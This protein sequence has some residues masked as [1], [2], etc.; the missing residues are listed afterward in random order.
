MQEL[1]VWDDPIGVGSD[2]KAHD[3]LV[4]IY[5]NPKMPLHTRMRAAIAAIPYESPKLAVT[6][7]MT[8][9]DFASILEARMRRFKK[10]EAA[11]VINAQPTP[12]VEVKP[13]LPT[14]A[15]R[16]YRRI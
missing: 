1:L 3:I 14:V 11:K 13:H 10:L 4:A 5:R 12:V 15:D 8:G 9:K 7:V 16:R 2:A 6:A